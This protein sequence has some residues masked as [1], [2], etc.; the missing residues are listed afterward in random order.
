M[1]SVAE[2][3]NKPFVTVVIPTLNEAGRIEDSR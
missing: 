1:E 3:A 2:N